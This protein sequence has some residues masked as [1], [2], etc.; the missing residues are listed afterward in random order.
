[1]I[2][3]IKMINREKKFGFIRSGS[4]DYFFHFTA[5]KNVDFDTL[6]KDQEVTFE[7]AESEKGLRAEDVYA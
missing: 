6:Q 3:T 1:M 2:G 5:C 7:E 4:S